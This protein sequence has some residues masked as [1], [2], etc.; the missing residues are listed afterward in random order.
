MKYIQMAAMVAKTTTKNIEGL[1]IAQ[2]TTA[3]RGRESEIVKKIEQ[4]SQGPDVYRVECP[5]QIATSVPTKQ[6]YKVRFDT[7]TCK[8]CPLKENCQ[9]FKNK[10]RYYFGHEDY[11]LGKRNSNI[12][13]IPRERRKIRPN[14]EALMKEFKTRTRN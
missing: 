10:G 2:I 6:R 7:N 3:V 9:I 13:N 1:K 5:G 12:S 11:L 8:D 14:V 4:I